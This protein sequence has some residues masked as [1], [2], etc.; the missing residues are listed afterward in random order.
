MCDTS[1]PAVGVPG[2]RCP[3]SVGRAAAEGAVPV[4]AA[5]PALGSSP[6]QGFPV[7]S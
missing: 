7:L 3:V 2:P 6:V 4:L 1:L 5:L